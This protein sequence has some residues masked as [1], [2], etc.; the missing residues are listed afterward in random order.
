MEK[1]GEYDDDAGL[2][3]RGV[4]V[5][6]PASEEERYTWIMKTRMGFLGS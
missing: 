4:S 6:V 5:G 1:S 3:N 2:E